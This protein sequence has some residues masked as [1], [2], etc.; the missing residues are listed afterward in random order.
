M[1]KSVTWRAKIHI[2]GKTQ[3]VFEIFSTQATVREVLLPQ[4]FTVV[5]E[6]CRSCMR[7]LETVKSPFFARNFAKNLYCVIGYLQLAVRHYDQV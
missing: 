5:E 6:K 2:F 3:S 7:R 1:K 4:Q